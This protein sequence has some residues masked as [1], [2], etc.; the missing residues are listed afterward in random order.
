MRG[1]STVRSTFWTGETGRALRGLPEEKRHL[2]QTVALYLVTSP[3]ANM[4]GLYYLPITLLCHEIGCPF[5]GASKALRSLYEVNFCDYDIETEMVWVYEM[6]RYQVGGSLKASDK[7]VHGIAKE[8]ESLQKNRFLEA[9][10]DRYKADFHLEKCRK[11]EAPSKP[12]RSP[13]QGTTRLEQ[14]QEQE[15]EQEHLSPPVSPPSGGAPQP[16]PKKK[17]TP[18]P[19]SFPLTDD[20][21]RWAQT[22]GLNG[23]IQPVTD[24]FLDHHRAKGS[25][26]LDWVAA[27]RTWIRNEVKFSRAKPA[28]QGKVVPLDWKTQHN[29]AVGAAFIGNTGGNDES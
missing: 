4:I 27:W 25:K 3:H 19:D 24:S 28:Q 13:S 16:K 11:N 17:P 6:A 9:F 12:L 15:Q 23:D 21:I 20:M 7:R 22:Q 18:A 1:Y 29:L 26:F 10:F 5:E 8:Y 14:E 2:C